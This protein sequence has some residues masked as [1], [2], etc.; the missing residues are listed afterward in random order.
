MQVM[1]MGRWAALLVLVGCGADGAGSG[2]PS[3]SGAG[4]EDG[5]AGS[6]GAEGSEGGHGGNGGAGAQGGEPDIDTSP[7]EVRPHLVIAQQ[8]AVG[9]TDLTIRVRAANERLTVRRIAADCDVELIPSSESLENRNHFGVITVSSSGGSLVTSPDSIGTYS[10]V[11][12]AGS[13]WA[14][15]D[16]VRFQAEGDGH[17]GF[18]ETLPAPGEIQPNALPDGPVSPPFEVRWTGGGI[19]KVIVALVTSGLPEDH[20]LRCF[21][22]AAE[23]HFTVTSELA[24]LLPTPT[25]TLVVMTESRRTL[26]RGLD[27][28]RLMA[29]GELHRRS[30]TLN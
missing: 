7:R 6:A 19:G 5:Q 14:T 4:G 1:G 16:F 18:D 21:V 22:D 27:E 15:E 26:T 23:G 30:I 2:P 3:S 28:I 10:G 13:L 29:R 8:Q 20:Q 11:S 24:E 9:P 25:V 12:S 17:P